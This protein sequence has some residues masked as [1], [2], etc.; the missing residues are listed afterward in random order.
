LAIAARA[1]P[2]GGTSASHPHERERFKRT[3]LGVQYG[4]GRARLARQ[5]GISESAAQAL[6]TNHKS[7]FPKFW[8][9]ADRAETSAYLRREIRSVFGWRLAIDA[10][11]K[12]GTIRNFP[13]Q[14][15]GAEILRIAC[16]MMTEAGIS[17]CAP[18][19]DA[20]LIEAP[21]SC[22]EETVFEARRMMAEASAIVLDGFTL[23]TSVRAVR[24]PEN[25]TDPRGEMIWAAVQRELDRPTCSPE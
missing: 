3:A 16:C 22:F 25:W 10:E 20:V 8:S 13:M 19:H 12:P 2:K 5:L 7:A 11:T 9:W 1:A 6:I 14:A 17:V 4:I 23:R 21:L 24:A 18:N 15:N